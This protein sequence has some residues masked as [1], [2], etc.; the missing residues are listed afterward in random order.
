MISRPTA[1]EPVNATLST[2]GCEASLAPTSGPSPVIRLKTPG[3]TPHSWATCAS[4]NSDSGV[5]SSTLTTTELPAA[6]AGATFQ[7]PSTSGKFHGTIAAH[8][9]IG[10]RR[11]LFVDMVGYAGRGTACSNS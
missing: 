7:I 6:S 9:P 11:I 3:G 5:F 1:V 2:S 10:S 4:R 8:T